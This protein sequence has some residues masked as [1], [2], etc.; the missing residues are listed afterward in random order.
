[1]A[2]V[3]VALAQMAVGQTQEPRVDGIPVSQLSFET[4]KITENLYILTGVSPPVPGTTA[5]GGRFG[6][7]IGVLTGPDGIFMVDSQYPPVA[8]KVLAAI[9]RFSNAPIRYLV[10]SHHHIDHAGG[11]AFFAKQG[12][13]IMH[14]P[15]MRERLA[16]ARNADPDSLAK[17]TIE[18]PLTF[19]MNG[20]E[21]RVIPMEGGGHTDND[22]IVWF[23]N[24]DVLFTG[25]MVRVGYPNGLGNPN[26]GSLDGLID[27]YGR[28]IGLIGPNTKVIPGH[29][30]L[31][32]WW[33]RQHLIEYRD[34][35]A[36]VRERLLKLI[37]E[38]KSLEDIYAAGLT[39]DFDKPI[40]KS[41]E[42]VASAYDE[43]MYPRFPNP[44]EF[45]R[46]AY[47]QYTGQ[48][49]PDPLAPVGDPRRLAQGVPSPG[50]R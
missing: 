18:G 13:T 9:R 26:G 1:M 39:G 24:A 46:T 21:I 43:G 27:H 33:N 16:A 47:N 36:T 37:K 23:K 50:L 8:D 3:V 7:P 17:V 44:R 31:N 4:A 40:L 35:M 34:M 12:A 30:P 41:V 45:L 15:L 6:G 20:E 29:A 25:D 2:L 10:N 42:Y 48:N 19:Y 22:T 49:I 32:E 14:R 38:G 5:K 28:M 11:N